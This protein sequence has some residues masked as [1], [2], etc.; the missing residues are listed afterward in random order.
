MTLHNGWHLST[1]HA[2]ASYG[3]TVLVSPDGTAYGEADLL[4]TTQTAQALGV[5]QRRV[6]Q[7][8]TDGRFPRARKLGRDWLIPAS[9]VTRFEPGPA[10]N[11]NWRKS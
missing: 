9:D 1:D 11:P 10:G 5:N 6:Q 7:L 4:T 3:E 2:A 8:V